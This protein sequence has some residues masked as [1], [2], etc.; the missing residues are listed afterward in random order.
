MKKMLLL[1]ATVALSFS[2]LACKKG[3]VEGTYALDKAAMKAAAEA[4][5]AKMD[6]KKQGFAKFGLAMIDMMNISLSLEAGGKATMN[7]EMPN[8][9]KKGEIRKKA[10]M[11]TWKMD[12]AKVV[13]TT[14]R[15]SAKTKTK[16]ESTVS[17]DLS[18]NKLTCSGLVGKRKE[19]LVFIKG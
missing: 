8:P 5:I 13:I 9:F 16:K 11:G 10:D 19:T 3:A 4:E 2:L 15:E 6:P 12:G 18:G 17:C 7:T 1:I 14:T